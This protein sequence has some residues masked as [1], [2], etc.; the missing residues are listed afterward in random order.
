MV[1]FAFLG[2]YTF[3][4]IEENAMLNRSV[5]DVSWVKYKDDCGINAFQAN[6]RNAFR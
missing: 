4:K 3:I 6:P 2:I 1:V 5:S